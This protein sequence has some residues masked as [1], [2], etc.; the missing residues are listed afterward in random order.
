M[1]DG[2]DVALEEFKALRAEIL[3]VQQFQNAAFAAALTAI[4]A[5]GSFALTKSGGRH[6]LLLVLPIVLSGLGL[7]QAQC[8]RETNQ[9]G[10]YVRDH[11]WARLPVHEGDPFRSWEHFVARSHR[12]LHGIVARILIFGV[13]SV[14]SLVITDQQWNTRLAPLWWGDVAVLLIFGAL[15]LSVVLHGGA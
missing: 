9:I 11:L 12:R 13:P 5:V 10:N 6:E 3:A 4:A 8:A 1:V 15:S 14:V 7:L 2:S